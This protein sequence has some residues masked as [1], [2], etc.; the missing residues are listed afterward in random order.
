MKQPH[1]IPISDTVYQLNEDYEYVWITN[2][3]VNKIKVPKG[4]RYDGATV[5]RILWSITGILP[6]GP[7]RAGTLLHDW[8]YKFEGN[9]PEGSHTFISYNEYN[10]TPNFHK[11]IGKWSRKD[12]DKL[13]RKMWVEAGVKSSNL[14]YLF[15]RIFGF[16]FWKQ[17]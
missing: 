12:A 6:D 2:N 14:M 13:A 11:V 7:H 8:I 3:V 9:L 15:V 16:F 10:L 17:L 4:F 5:P 1:I